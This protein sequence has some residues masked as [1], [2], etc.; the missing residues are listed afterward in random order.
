MPSV[1]VGQHINIW[2]YSFGTWIKRRRKALDLTQQELAQ[3]VGCSISLVF[4]IE[5]D[6]RRPSRQIAE[7]LA[8]HLEIPSDQ[9]D[10]F[11]KVARQEKA[12]DQ[13][14]SISAP[15]E[16]TSAATSQPVSSNLPLSLTSIIG[17]EYELQAI[18]QQL[19]D[20]LCRLL[21]LTGPGGVGKTR[22]ALEIAHRMSQIFNHG[23]YFIS[24]VGT[25]ASDFIVPAIADAL[26]FAFSGTTDLKVQLF[27]YLKEKHI[28]LVLDNLEHL[29]NGIELL[30]ELLEQAPQVKLLTTSREPLN[31]RAEWIFEVQ[32]LP[33][34]SHIE[35]NDLE[36]NSAAALFFQRAK[37]ANANFSPSAENLSAITR[38]CQLVEGLP[39]GLELAAAWVRMMSLPEIVREIE[40]SMDFLTTAARDAPQRHRS[41]RAV[42]DYSW[43]LLSDEERQVMRRLSIF[44]GGFTREAAEQVTR[45]ALPLLSAL[46]D[47]SLVR[48]NESGR[49]DLHEL[50]RQYAALQLQA[51]PEEEAKVRVQHTTHFLSLLETRK[52][53]LQ[54]RR[55]RDALAELSPETD[56]IRYAWDEAV[57]DRRLEL[58]RR[59]AWSLWYVYELRTYF[60]EG[61]ALIKRGLD[62]VRTWL[63]EI[64]PKSPSPER[65][66][67]E[68]TLGALI[69]HQ[70]FFCF[71]LGRNLESQELFEESIALLKPLNEASALA[72]ALGHYGVLRS[73][74]GAYE[75]AVRNTS[76]SIELSRSIN[77]RW[78]VGLYTTFLGMAV[79]DQ[80]KYDEAYRLFSEALQICRSLGDPRLISL[81]AGYLGQ[82]AH[83]LGRREEVADLLR[84]GL[85]AAAET[86]DRFGIALAGVRMAMAAQSRGGGSGARRMLT[87]SIQHFRDAGDSWFLSHA[88]NLEGKI[89]FASGQYTQARES[90]SEAGKV[91]FT[92]QAIPM[93]LDALAGL[94]AVDAQMGKPEQALEWA[95]Y[96]LGHPSSTQD[97][98]KRT[99]KL[100]DE[101]EVQFPPQQIK[102]SHSRAHAMRLD[103]LVQELGKH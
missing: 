55:Q 20:P 7:L 80:G 66:R 45:A 21:T 54:S 84:E 6:E 102:A 32:G 22:L 81:A 46:I 79:D 23:A 10:L 83:T 27:N 61:E 13:L 43:G 94:A 90:F 87:E 37:Q 31:L 75:D 57:S 52:P 101:I 63:T 39:L 76:A 48:R 60:Q 2:D 88:L 98:R 42:F 68:G 64:D 15:S 100:R 73:L 49:Y 8:K 96:I 59:A 44:R 77:D 28:L 103:I 18:S 91:A 56:N 1:S 9:R 78:Q 24:L 70:A 47:K 29:L 11:L 25:S 35:L 82:T 62:A 5:S 33:V 41:M 92:S 85:Q 50:L 67:A 71:R 97:T 86:N 40:R 58:I 3:R 93:L 26:G 72:F 65:A 12:A 89:A 99:E 38:I 51:E 19:Q 16:A 30:D 74:Q 4:K 34:S 95:I 17:R 53:I 14:E 69:A 36:S